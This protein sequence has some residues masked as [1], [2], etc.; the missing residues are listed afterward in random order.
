M[1]EEA[2]NIAS[3]VESQKQSG[4]DKSDKQTNSITSKQ[5]NS[6]PIVDH[7]TPKLTYSQVAIA[8]RRSLLKTWLASVIGTACA[9]ALV[10]GIKDMR[11]L[12]TTSMSAG[13]IAFVVTA[14]GNN[15]GNK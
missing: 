6:K 9:F 13:S 4:S 2:S 10:S 3:S 7:P 14:Q 5:P 12:V 1:F 8:E 11:A 15:N